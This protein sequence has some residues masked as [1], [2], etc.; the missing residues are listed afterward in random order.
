MLSDT[1]ALSGGSIDEAAAGEQ[2]PFGPA[3][4][5]GGSEDPREEPGEAGSWGLPAVSC[6]RPLKAYRTPAG[7]VKIGGAP[8]DCRSLELPCFRCIGCKLDRSRAWSLR[9]M[10]EAQLYDSNLCLTLTYSD[11]NLPRSM[12]LEYPDFAGF[13]KR[14]RRRM[15]GV[16]RL[17]DGR[18]PIRFFV[19]GE[20]GERTQ[21]PHFHAVLFNTAFPDMLQ[22]KNGKFLSSIVDELWQHRGN[23]LVDRL[24]SAAAAYVAGYTLKKARESVYAESVVDM[25][26]GELLDRRPPFVVMSRR[27]GIGAEWYRKFGSDLFPHDFAVAGDGK[28]YKVP[29]Y[30]FERF[31]A[32]ADAGVVEDILER[33]Y[34]KAAEH[35]EES[36]PERRAVREE[37]AQLLSEQFAERGL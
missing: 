26:T 25:R 21:R 31:K 13:M 27:P 9:I 35:P 2:G 6:Y 33:R 15:V 37:R 18:K 8:G 10:H 3:V 7:E 29:R 23:V 34:L 11:E 22:M 14:L 4:Q 1:L 36:R 28:R 24:S 20:Y 5:E 32:S 17:P 30:Y 19:C 12:S 16:T